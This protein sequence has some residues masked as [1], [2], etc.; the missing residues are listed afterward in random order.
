MPAQFPHNENASCLLIV[1][2]NSNT[3]GYYYLWVQTGVHLIHKHTA[4][5]MIQLLCRRFSQNGNTVYKLCLTLSGG[6]SAVQIVPSLIMLVLLAVFE[7]ITLTNMTF[8]GN[9]CVCARVLTRVC[10][11]CVCDMY[12]HIRVCECRKHTTD[13][14]WR[15]EVNLRYWS[16]L[17]SGYETGSLLCCPHCGGRL[18]GQEI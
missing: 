5:C 16:S 4:C 11:V 1:H 17:S 7:Q 6:G 12:V 18:A 15:S 10:R 2:L 3:L 14:V 13:S 9:S 8:T